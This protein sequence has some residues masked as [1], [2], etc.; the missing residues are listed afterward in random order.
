MNK[1]IAV[2]IVT[3]GALFGAYSYA[4]TAG[5]GS[6]SLIED[7]QSDLFTLTVSDPEGVASFALEFKG[8]LPYSGDLSGCQRSKSINN[9]AAISDSDLTETVKGRVVDC[10]GSET[11]FEI[12]A[13]DTKGKAQVKKL[14]AEPVKTP[15][16]T[17]TTPTKSTEVKE[18]TT[19]A[20]KAEEID[21]PVPELGNCKNK[22]SCFEYCELSENG[23]KCL[24]FAKKHKLF[25]EDE[26]NVAEKVLGIKGGPGGCNSKKSC[27]DFCN[28]VSQINEC[29]IFA[30]ENGL[31]KGKELE[32]AK[33]IRV[34]LQSGQKMP[35]DC[36]N[37]IACENYCRGSEHIDECLAFAESAGFLSPEELEQAKIFMPLMKKGE[38]PGAC[39]SREECDAYCESDEHFEECINFAEK[40]GMIPEEEREHIEAFKKAGGKGPGGCKG[41][42]CQAFC[43]NPDNQQACFEWAKDNGLLKEEDVRRMEE[44][45]QQLEKVLGDAP[46]E[47]QECIE[48]AI[49]GGLEAL[50]SGKF[51]GGEAVG[52]KIRACF[53]GFMSQMGG[54]FGGPD[55]EHGGPGGPGGGDFSGPGGCKGPDEC[56]S[57][58]KDHLEEC[59]KFAPP[60]GQN[61]EHDGPVKC[62][63]EENPEEC[64][65]LEPPHRNGSGGPGGCTN[66]EECQAYC[67]K[68][69]EECKSFGSQ[70][71]GQQIQ[72]PSD[73]F[74]QEYKKQ[75]EQQGAEQFQQQYQQ[76]FQKQSE[77]Q[78]RQQY[79]QQYQQQTQQQYPTSQEDYC[80]QY[81][82]K[83]QPLPPPPTS[84][85]ISPLGLILSPFVEI[86]R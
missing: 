2:L 12:S 20:P 38:T 66:P 59:Q 7:L 65:Q 53:E 48:Q 22:E 27:E 44:G 78:Y 43:E 60:G 17:P 11:E 18:T 5:N 72:P 73:Q 37:K 36:R 41:R 54:T 50:R 8:K 86:L 9:I 82:E 1:F 79:E 34:A 83:C 24:E 80:K 81:P 77:E 46:P 10:Q 55:G 40:H 30:E 69:P 52:E 76:E 39:K 35:G 56:M 25:P 45:K 16:P 63:T 70:G 74:Q 85:V 71:S 51:F 49:P 13:V 3:L 68:N 6:L 84:S 29:I 26:I 19:S 47:V 57:Y 33:K 61:G 31:M 14:G 21:Y 28:D 15:A 4:Q 42:Q 58:C 64:L 32:E 23:K 67:E 62:G 75:F